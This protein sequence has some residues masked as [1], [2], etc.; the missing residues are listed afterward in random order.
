MRLSL[1]SLLLCRPKLRPDRGLFLFAA[2]LIGMDGLRKVNQGNRLT[3]L[4]FLFQF[5]DGG[6]LRRVVDDTVKIV[7]VLLNNIL[8]VL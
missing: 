7:V 1:G 3:R 2:L 4:C 5:P 6:R 8:D